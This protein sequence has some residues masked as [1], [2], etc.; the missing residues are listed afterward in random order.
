MTEIKKA[1]AGFEMERLKA[2][3]G[4]KG[5]YVADIWQTGVYLEDEKG[6]K[7]VGPGVQSILWSDERV[8]AEMGEA[9]GN[10]AMFLIT[11]FAVSRVRGMRFKTP[12]H[13]LEDIFEEVYTYGKLVT[14]RPDLKKTFVLN[15]LVPVDLAAWQLYARENEIV[16]FDGMIPDSMRPALSSRQEK[17]ASIPLITYGMGTEDIKREVDKGSFFLKIKIGCDPDNDG[18]LDKMLRWDMDRLSQIH[19]ILKDV[20][21]PYT[22]TGKIPYYLDAN[23][24]YDSKERLLKLLEHADRIGALEHII[25]LEGPFPEGADIYVGDLPVRAAA[26][27]S[28]HSDED[29]GR[30]IEKGYKAIAL[31]PIAKT[32]SMT[33]KICETAYA[34]GIPCF[35]ADLTV[36]PLMVEWNKNVAARIGS[37]PGMK[38]GVLES[39]GYQNY[40]NWEMMKTY[41][42]R[43][44]AS[45]TEDRNG[46]YELDGE[47]YKSSGGILE[48]SEHYRNLAY[49]R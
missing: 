20:R 30:L 43:C 14:G 49:G 38:I 10:A 11:Q 24:R 7:G 40:V 19:E 18:D 26:D 37:L 15:S 5:G 1:G 29:V 42:P 21:T 17:L 44:G 46:I 41:H 39:N 36:N 9:G 48:S 8:F 13:L 2:P 45:F 34:R 4:F 28:A 33:L 27:E 32:L 31:K 12:I 22:R 47:F 16:D 25:L 6:I 35:C 23:G 3:F